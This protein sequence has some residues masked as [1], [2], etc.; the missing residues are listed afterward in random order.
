MTI[1]SSVYEKPMAHEKMVGETKNTSATEAFQ[2]EALAELGKSAGKGSVQDPRFI[3]K[4][5]GSDPLLKAEH[6]IVGSPR[7]G[8]KDQVVITVPPGKGEQIIVKP[9]PGGS[10]QIEIK[11]LPGFDF[12][13]HGGEQHRP[14][15]DCFPPGEMP[16]DGGAHHFPHEGRF[17]VDEK[18]IDGGHSGVL[19]RDGLGKLYGADRGIDDLFWRPGIDHARIDDLVW[20]PGIDHAEVKPLN[21]RPIF[22]IPVEGED[23]LRR[24]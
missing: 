10:E 14:P 3:E 21:A 8:A 15:R 6:E 20:R 23:N 16:S 24:R 13:P 22:P 1:D 11:P 17:P 12:H 19:T 9:G 7:L 4:I 5:A 18:P 2:N